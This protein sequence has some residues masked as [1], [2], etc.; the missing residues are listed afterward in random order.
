MICRKIPQKTTWREMV[1]SVKTIY[2]YCLDRSI[3][4]NEK[5]RDK[6][7]QKKY[8]EEGTFTEMD[9]REVN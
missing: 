3:K 5:Y 4:R 1:K 7:Q 9:K 2:R 8:R 6:K